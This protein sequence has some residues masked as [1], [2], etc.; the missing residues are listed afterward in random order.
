MRLM[1]YKELGGGRQCA[2]FI[3][4]VGEVLA[5][6]NDCSHTCHVAPESFATHHD[7]CYECD[8]NGNV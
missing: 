2:L 8:C 6:H 5:V 1:N 7:R 3:K 4:K